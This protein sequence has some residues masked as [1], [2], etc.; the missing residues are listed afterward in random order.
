MRKLSYTEEQ[1]VVVEALMEDIYGTFYEMTKQPNNPNEPDESTGFIY[2]YF[3]GEELVGAV[4]VNDYVERY[5]I[6]IIKKP[7]IVH[8]GVKDKVKNRNMI[9]EKL[10][11]KA[12]EEAKT[13]SNE[14]YAIFI[15]VVSRQNRDWHVKPNDKAVLDT[16]HFTTATLSYPGVYRVKLQ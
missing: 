10:L 16:L 13:K 4:V 5:A 14:L 11:K 7:T 1:F 6:G 9:A 8:Y 3:S 15:L 12:M 2:G